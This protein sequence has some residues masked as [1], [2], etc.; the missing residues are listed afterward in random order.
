MGISITMGLATKLRL[1]QDFHNN[2][3]EALPRMV[4]LPIVWYMFVD[5]G[6]DGAFSCNNI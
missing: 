5:I 4:H 1:D 6:T 3:G 2:R